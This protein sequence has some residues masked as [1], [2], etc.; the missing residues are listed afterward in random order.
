M[1]ATL[2]PDVIIL[3]KYIACHS[4]FMFC[5]IVGDSSSQQPNNND[6]SYSTIPGGH[7]TDSDSSSENQTLATALQTFFTPSLQQVH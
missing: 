5:K 7:P 3:A 2:W 6:V 4:D 1:T